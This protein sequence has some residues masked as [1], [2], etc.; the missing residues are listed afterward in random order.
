MPRRV[1]LLVW[2]QMTIAVK[3]SPRA[4]DQ[5]GISGS[6]GLDDRSVA[7]EMNR[8]LVNADRLP[9]V[10]ADQHHDLTR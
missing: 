6:R 9:A 1:G 4:P 7:V 5:I 2:R 8:R 10:R 3:E